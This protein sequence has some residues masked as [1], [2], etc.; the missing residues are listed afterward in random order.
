MTESILSL[1]WSDNPTPIG[2][3]FRPRT[4]ARLLDLFLHYLAGAVAAAAV[5]VLIGLGAGLRGEDPTPLL[6]K[7]EGFSAIGMLLSFL[8]AILYH[9]LAESLDG[10]TPGK[11]ICGL[12]VLTESQTPCSFK[13]AFGRSL[14]FYVD[15][16][17][18]GLIAY[19]NMSDSPMR[20]R[21]GD[22]WNHTIVQRRADA[23]PVSLRPTSRFIA[24]SIAAFIVD[25][26][27]LFLAFVLKALA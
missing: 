18:F 20:Q 7:L 12:V 10:S 5:A 3:G 6:A 27:I 16:L 14:A 9:T 21:L 4:L 26:L 11:R 22:K 23:P 24:V 2:A 19:G 15:G 13:A 8:G 1:G 25:T 17:F